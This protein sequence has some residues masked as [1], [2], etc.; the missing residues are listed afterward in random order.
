MIDLQMFLVV[1]QQRALIDWLFVE[2]AQGLGIIY[3][4]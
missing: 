2:V 3:I 1:F 4:L